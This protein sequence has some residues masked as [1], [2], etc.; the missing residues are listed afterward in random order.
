[1][2]KL[3]GHS[4]YAY[5]ALVKRPDYSWPEGKRLAC[6]IALNIEHFAFGTGVGMDPVHRNGPQTTRNFA[7]RDYGNR[8]GNW[9]LF[10]VLDEL[11]LPASVLLNS[12]V[13]D[14]YPELVEKIKAR[15][16]D[17]LGHGRTNAELHRPMWEDDEARAIRECTEVIEKHIGVRPTGWMG[18]GAMESS[19]TPDLLKEAGYT[20]LL[21]W[22]FDDQP[23]WMTTRAGPLLS[24]PY[25][26]ELN[27]A[28]TLSWRDQTGRE[29]ADMIVD[30][31]EEMLEQSD[32]HPLVF[33]LALH[34]FIVGQPF[35]LR[36]L[37][38]AIKHCATHKRK[39]Q[40]WFTRA[41]DIAKHCFALPKG[42]VP[43]S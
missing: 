6:Y 14:N 40:V 5:S 22:P 8:I 41:G 38:Q 32:R 26:M 10:E 16:D 12:S 37:R 15:G 36:P 18:P 1:M 19:L 29:F 24:V 43:G 21:D 23:A 9:R 13:C 11:K 28:S 25:P 35:R 7:W 17:V 42:T 20:Y 31:F 4:R 39:D 3:P 2:L 34:G 30:Q 33:A 27:D